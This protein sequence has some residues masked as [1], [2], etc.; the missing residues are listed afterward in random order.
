MLRFKISNLKFNSK[1]FA[2]SIIL[3]I[4]VAYFFNYREISNQSVILGYPL[5]WLTIYDVFKE[6]RLFLST[7]ID[8]MEFLINDAFY[9]ILLKLLY[10]I[11]LKLKIKL[12]F[13][14]KHNIIS[15][16]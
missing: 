14:N 13:N 9:Y 7:N 6:H 5:S 8:I 10:F 11:K 1:L 16:K 3:N 4:L 12:I 2:Y 15:D